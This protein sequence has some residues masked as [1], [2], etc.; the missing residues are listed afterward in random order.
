MFLLVLDV[1]L[2]RAMSGQRG[3]L[4]GNYKSFEYLHFSDDLCLLNHSF[5]D[6]VKLSVLQIKAVKTIL[7]IDTY[8]T[9]EMRFQDLNTIKLRLDDQVIRK[10]EK[11]SYCASVTTT[12]G[13][14]AED[15]NK[16]INRAVGA[17]VTYTLNIYKTEDEDQV[18]DVR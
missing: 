4:C 7:K 15:I 6:T 8:E 18:A 11:F 1:V 2:A 10:V 9:K 5:K 12:H 16:R 14:T 13:E 3:I 17:F